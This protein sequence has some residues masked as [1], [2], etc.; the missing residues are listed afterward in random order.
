MSLAL[1]LLPTC[2]AGA[3]T[4]LKPSDRIPNAMQMV[5]AK[6]ALGVK[7]GADHAMRAYLTACLFQANNGSV[8]SVLFQM[9]FQD[10][11]ASPMRL[12][13]K[14][15]VHA[16][17]YAYAR[18]I[19]PLAQDFKRGRIQKPKILEIGLGCGQSN[20]GAGVRMWDALF[21]T[22]A[23]KTR[24]QLDLHI[25]E[26]DER[27]VE[28]W[29]ARWA[30]SFKNVNLTI[31]V[32]SQSDRAVLT[33]FDNGYDAIID[34]GGHTME[35]QKVS[36]DML[37]SKLKPGGWYCIEDLVT[38]NRPQ[39]KQSGS[40]TTVELLVK[41]QRWMHGDPVEPSGELSEYTHVLPLI[42]HIDCYTEL[43]VLQRYPTVKRHS[44]LNE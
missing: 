35:Q 17:H 5:R 6:P 26:F 9:R 14:C 10:E 27:C 20:V 8:V 34:D 19:M 2:A 12:S 15:A 40:L 39:Y 16:Y 31:F 30:S 38:S 43:C 7:E 4:T 36:L 13:D 3:I 33:K 29:R 23:S 44:S 42:E 37:F 24:R 25:L 21:A 1:L 22:E 41:M 28:M 32:G 18:Y 11:R